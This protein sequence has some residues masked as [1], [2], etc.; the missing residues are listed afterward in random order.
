[1][2]KLCA[3][4]SFAVKLYADNEAQLLVECWVRRMTFL[5]SIYDSQE[6]TNYD[7]SVQDFNGIRN[8]D[9]FEAARKLAK[10]QVRTRF[11]SIAQLS[12]CKVL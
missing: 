12:P 6:A 3:T 9:E 8:S 7:Y 4:A 1:M 11:D 2:Y 5:Y 10:G